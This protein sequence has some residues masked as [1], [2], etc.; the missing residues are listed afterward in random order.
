[1][2][3]Q[4]HIEQGRVAAFTG[5]ERLGFIECRSGTDQHAFKVEQ[6]LA[7]QL[8]DEWLILHHEDTQSLQVHPTIPIP[9]R[10]TMDPQRGHGLQT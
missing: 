7:Y 1:M 10:S 8:G 5:G 6:H 2:A 4:S 9:I 3:F